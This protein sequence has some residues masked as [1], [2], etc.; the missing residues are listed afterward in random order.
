MS[1]PCRV[2]TGHATVTTNPPGDGCLYGDEG[3]R[4]PAVGEGTIRGS[5]RS[6]SADRTWFRGLI[7][8]PAQLSDPGLSRHTGGMPLTVG[9][10]FDYL[11]GTPRQTPVTIEGPMPNDH[12]LFV[13]DIDITHDERGGADEI[14]VSWRLGDAKLVGP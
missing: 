8:I 13:D 7:G 2:I 6:A 1:R 11:A 9:D 4:D 10:L 14:V 3:H 5:V 12:T